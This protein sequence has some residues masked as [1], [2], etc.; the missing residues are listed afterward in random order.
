MENS[1]THWGVLALIAFI[2][3]LWVAH[4]LPPVHKAKTRA[5]RI[6]TVNHVASVSI[7]MPSTNALPTGTTNR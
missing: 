7:T 2:A 6:Q 1:K 3:L 5:Q 4:I